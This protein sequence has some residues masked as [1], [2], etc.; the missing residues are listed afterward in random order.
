MKQETTFSAHD[1]Q[2]QFA[3]TFDLLARCHSVHNVFDDFLHCTINSFCLNY[4][5]TYMDPICK[6]Y[7]QE[8]RHDFGKLIQ[9]WI[10]ILDKNIPD[11]QSWFDFFGHFYEELSLT[12]T[13]GFSQFFTPQSLCTMMV[14]LTSP[15]ERQHLYE[16][17]CGAGRMNLAAHA[18]NPRMFHVANDM[19]YTCVMMS[20][21]NFMAHGIRGIVTCE[22]AL[23]PGRHWR[24]AFIINHKLA[25][26]IQY[27]ADRETANAYIYENT[28]SDLDK[29]RQLYTSY[30]ELLAPPQTKPVSQSPDTPPVKVDANGQLS[31]F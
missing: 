19:D 16:P 31:L 11:D 23:L 6:R 29:F 12:K 24:G 28:T 27:V 2:K 21:C 3:N 22:D 15:A 10:Q 17:A 30:S 20:A 4:P 18:I 9:L 5:R 26:S 25:P 13:R 1:L 7:T 14:E 8:E